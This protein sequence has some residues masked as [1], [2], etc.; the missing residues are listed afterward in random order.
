MNFVLHKKGFPMMDIP[1]RHRAG[2]YR[3]LEKSQTSKD[4]YVFVG[5]FLRRYLD[6]NTRLIEISKKLAK[7]KM[8]QSGSKA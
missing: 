1:Y 5:W 3:A 4:E 8:P 7:G 2:Y 6:Q